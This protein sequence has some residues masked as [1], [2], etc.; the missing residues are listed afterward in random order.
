[1][2]KLLE[3]NDIVVVNNAWTGKKE[4][5]VLQISDNWAKTDFRIFNRK[6][7]KDGILKEHNQRGKT[8]WYD[9]EY[10]YIEKQY[11]MSQMIAD[12]NTELQRAFDQ[13]QECIGKL[14]L[15]KD[16][17][18]D[19]IVFIDKRIAEEKEMI[20]LCRKRAQEQNCEHI[21]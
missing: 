20:Q 4:Y 10:Y 12:R 7:G 3:V 15:E 9:N 17:I 2:K 16:K 5:P 19:R 11:T 6:I 1:M 18:N 14:E 8:Q 13:A 21:L